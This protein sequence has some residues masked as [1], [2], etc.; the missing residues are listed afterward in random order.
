MALSL[1]RR[2]L[3]QRLAL[4]ASTQA[5]RVDSVETRLTGLAERQCQCVAQSAAG[6]PAY[7]E[8]HG[9]SLVALAVAVFT[10]GLHLLG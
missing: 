8:R 10:L 6:W 1:S 9:V 3:R 4:A 2:L 7:L 5:D